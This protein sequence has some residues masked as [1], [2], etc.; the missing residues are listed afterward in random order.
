MSTVNIDQPAYPTKN[1]IRPNRRMIVQI[2]TVVGFI[3]A[4][5]LVFFVEFV[6]NQRK[7]HSG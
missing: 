5:F 6:H 2:T 3:S 1:P 4:I 7:K